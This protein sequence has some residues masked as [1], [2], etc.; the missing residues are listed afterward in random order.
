M[1][2]ETQ[3]QSGHV[4]YRVNPRNRR[5]VQRQRCMGARWEPYALCASE[6]DAQAVL[7]RLARRGEGG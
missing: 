7:L 2:L 3:P 5:E 1:T 6:A 4:R